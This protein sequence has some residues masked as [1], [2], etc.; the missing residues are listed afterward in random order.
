MKAVAVE[1]KSAP[2]KAELSAEKVTSCDLA[3][4]VL[5]A[6]AQI[7]WAS[8]PVAKRLHVVRIA[9]QI[10]ASRAEEFAAAISP[11]LA[12]TRADTLV[13][14]LLPLLEACRFLERESE[15]LLAPRKLGSRGQPLWLRGVVAEVH[16]EPLGHVLVIG[17]ANFPLFLPGVQTLQ[18]I[19]AGNTVTWKPGEGGGAVAQLVAEVLH[20]AGLPEGVLTVTNDSVEAAQWAMAEKPDKVIFTGSAGSAKSVLSKLAET[21]TPAVVE[22]SGADAIVVTPSAD[23]AHVAKAIAFGLRLNGGAVCMSPRR[24]FAAS[25]TMAALRPRSPGCGRCSMRPLLRAQCYEVR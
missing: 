2:L 18:A 7:R 15:V 12:R 23:L 19:V 11:R 17:P 4:A 14:E 16:R 6:N 8:I 3:N 13:A 9:R 5:P 24:L 22:L 25:G 10:M 20:K 1:L 21:A